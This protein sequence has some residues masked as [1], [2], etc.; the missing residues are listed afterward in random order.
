[1]NDGYLQHMR[2]G[3]CAGLGVK[4][5]SRPDSKVVG[6]LG[7]GGM[8][9]T[10]TQAINEVRDI[11]LLRV[12][13]P[14]KANREAFAA[15][16]REQLGLNVETCDTAEAACRGVDII[17]MATDSLVQVMKPEWVE[18]GM[19]ITNVRSNEA[20][21]EVLAK[22]DLQARLGASTLVLDNPPAGT[23]HGSDGMFA[24][25]AGTDEERSKI[26]P[27]PI[28]EI[29][30]KN[31]GTIPDLMA[32]RWPGKDQRPAGDVPQQPGHP[33]PPVRR[34]G[35]HRLRG[36]PQAKGL[37]HPLPTGV[38]PAGHPRLGKVIRTAEHDVRVTAKG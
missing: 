33:G 17:A 37:G 14:T 9:R 27:S 2:V 1:M 34:G 20:G 3:A 22:C 16:M 23:I 19:H 15:E 6:M 4:Y 32:G 28:R 7:S 38:V 26:P 29:D 18:P 12:F 24:Y 35:G 10:Y 30:N 21:A 36:R 5:L 25:I 13:S 8:A 11:E 31:I